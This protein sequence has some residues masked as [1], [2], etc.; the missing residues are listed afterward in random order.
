MKCWISSIY[1]IEKWKMIWKPNIQGLSLDGEKIIGFLFLSQ[2][3]TKS[4]EILYK[5]RK[6]REYIGEK[7][8]GNTDYLETKRQ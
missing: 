2:T 3:L 6:I 4:S 1:S 8:R 7:I 5:L